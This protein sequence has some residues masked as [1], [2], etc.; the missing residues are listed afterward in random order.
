[1]P[2]ENKSSDE[3]Q[4]KIE[5]KYNYSFSS[6]N[7]KKISQILENITTEEYNSNMKTNIYFD[8]NSLKRISSYSF[9]IKSCYLNINILIYY[10][11]NY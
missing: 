3:I 8:D 11:K 2:K 9:E 10:C 7:N 4:S 6:S 5:N 1:M